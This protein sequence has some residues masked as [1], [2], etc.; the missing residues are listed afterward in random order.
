M[1]R[2]VRSM[3]FAIDATAAI[4]K[5]H[6]TMTKPIGRTLDG[7]RVKYVNGLSGWRINYPTLP[8]AVHRGRGTD[9][10]LS[11]HQAFD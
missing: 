6:K 7:L 9:T 8:A 3:E 2:T 4:R 5:T 10:T 1:V 11:T